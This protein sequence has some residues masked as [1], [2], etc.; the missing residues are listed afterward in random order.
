MRPHSAQLA[1]AVVSL[2]SRKPWAETHGPWQLAPFSWN[3][4]VFSTDGHLPMQ[5]NSHLHNGLH[6]QA[7]VW[8]ERIPEGAA[9]IAVVPHQKG[10]AGSHQSGKTFGR[11]AGDR[12]CG[13]NLGDLVVEC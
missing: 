9:L 6:Q 11:Q 10:I 2:L 7:S 1:S 8:F 13:G 3:R 5:H 4:P 12:Q